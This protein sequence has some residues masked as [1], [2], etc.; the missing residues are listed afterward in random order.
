MALTSGARTAQIPRLRI[1]T[2]GSKLALAQ[3]AE[4]RA[5]LDGGAWLC[6]GR[7]RD[8][9]DHN[10]GRQ[11]QVTGPWPKSAAKACS[12]R[13]SRRRSA[14][15]RRFRRPFDEGYARGAPR[16]GW[17]SPPRCRTKRTE[18]RWSTRTA[19]SGSATAARH[20]ARNPSLRRAASCCG[21]G[22]SSPS[23]RCAAMSIRACASLP[24]G[25]AQATLLAC[26]GLNRLG[27]STLPRRRRLSIGGNA[28]GGGARGDRH[29]DPGERRSDA[30]L[31]G[32]HQ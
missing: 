30:R 3:A 19:R 1:G 16:G 24:A 25:A 27:R 26:A 32:R 13:K 12:S 31:G 22:R 6:R 18:K 28:A 4:T 10:H 7:Y 9:D 15:A 2:R 5:R 14:K 20:E 21:I 23:C 11:D 29:R 8:R 17:S